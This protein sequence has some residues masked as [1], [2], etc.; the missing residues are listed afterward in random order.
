MKKMQLWTPMNDLWNLQDDM[1]RL[2]RGFGY[3]LKQR[4]RGEEGETGEEASCWAPVVDISEDNNEVK[5]VSE[6]PGMR[7]EDVKVSVD[8]GVLTIRGERKF[9]EEKHKKDYH[10]IERCYGNFTRSFTLPSNLQTDQIKANMHDGL[11][12]ITLPKK[13]EAKPKEIEI[14]VD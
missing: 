8:E 3:G 13:E 12:E 1:D 2:F 14:K 5:I 11:L 7:R 9:T 4:R 6:L 10:R